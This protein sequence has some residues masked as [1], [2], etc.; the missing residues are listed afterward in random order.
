MEIYSFGVL[1]SQLQPGKQVQG[2]YRAGGRLIAKMQLSSDSGRQT[3]AGSNFWRYDP[4]RFDPNSATRPKHRIGIA[5]G[6][7]GKQ[8]LFAIKYIIE[9]GTVRKEK[10]FRT[11]TSS[12]DHVRPPSKFSVRRGNWRQSGG[13]RCSTSYDKMESI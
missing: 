6:N 11:S 5:R 3:Q 9:S 4:H 7:T 1:Q 8:A 12:P 2:N 13:G 10:E